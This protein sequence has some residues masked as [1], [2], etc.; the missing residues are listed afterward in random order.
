MISSKDFHFAS[1]LSWAA[2]EYS[3]NL[4]ISGQQPRPIPYQK[5]H[6]ALLAEEP[7]QC[8]RYLDANPR[9]PAQVLCHSQR[10][11]EFPHPS[12]LNL[13]SSLPAK[14]KVT[15]L[16]LI[17]KSNLISKIKDVLLKHVAC[18]SYLHFWLFLIIRNNEHLLGITTFSVATMQKILIITS[19]STRYLL[20]GFPHCF[21]CKG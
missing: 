10:N 14:H 21:V 6:P 17:L 8:S 19:K 12:A 4:P 1:T 15:L 5:E 20:L 16:H 18:E 7:H 3:N 13:L 11:K 9:H 2:L